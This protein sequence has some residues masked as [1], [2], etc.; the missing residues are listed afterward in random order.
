MASAE[1]KCGM[2]TGDKVAI[3]KHRQG[4]QLQGEKQTTSLDAGDREGRKRR[5]EKCQSV[6]TTH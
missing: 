2:C 4:F 3:D 5:L 6:E 1:T